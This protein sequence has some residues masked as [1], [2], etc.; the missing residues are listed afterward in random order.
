MV[1][2]KEER[3][4]VRVGLLQHLVEIADRIAFRD[5]IKYHTARRFKKY[6]ILPRT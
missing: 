1:E 4:E 5:S 2:K 6:A 3:D